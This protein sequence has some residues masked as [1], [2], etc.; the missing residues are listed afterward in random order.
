MPWLSY[1][2][3]EQGPVRA[4]NEDFVLA[5][6]RN[7]F[8][9]VADGMG[10]HAGGDVAS[11]LACCVISEKLNHGNSLTN[12]IEAAHEQI[13]AKSIEDP[14]LK[15]MG[16]TVVAVQVIKTQLHLAW[17]GDSRIYRFNPQYGLVQLSKDHSFVQDLIDRDILSEQE[18][19]VHPQ[20]NLVLQALGQTK[21]K[22]LR[23]SLKVLKRRVD[24]LLLLCSDGVHDKLTNQQIAVCLTASANLAQQAQALR[25]AILATDANDNFSFIILRYQHS[26]SISKTFGMVWKLVVNAL[27]G[28][29]KR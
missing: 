10:G 21:V 1:A 24:D 5:D 29:R 11:Q 18:A 26:S 19:R 6:D 17:V 3:S 7:L 9:L 4:K 23:V 8:W 20:K 22:T 2:L 27:H 14:Q 12:A 13:I 15:G 16:T 25:S 28:L